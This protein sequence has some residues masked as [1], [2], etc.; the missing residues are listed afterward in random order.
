MGKSKRSDAETMA[1][2]QSG[3]IS[4]PPTDRLAELRK[5]IEAEPEK[6]ADS[7]LLPAIREAIGA[8]TRIETRFGMTRDDRIRFRHALFSD[9]L[10]RQ[11][12]PDMPTNAPELWS[13]RR[14][15]RE[16]PVE[17]VRRVYAPWLGQGL[18]R[19]HLLALDKQLY[20]ALGVW[21]HR[22]PDIGFPELE[23]EI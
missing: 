5:L 4:A 15:M 1:D 16:N 23:A 18:R 21:L 10:R 22:H 20:T 7:G 11:H 13:D 2:A 19:S 17:F 8:L 12:V 14:G 9:A 3:L 6:S